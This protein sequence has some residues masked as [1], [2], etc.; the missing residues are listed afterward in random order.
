MAESSLKDRVVVLVATVGVAFALLSGLSKHLDWVAQLCGIF[1]QGCQDT[2]KF[3]IL[4][5]PVW[6]W[7]IGFFACLIGTALFLPRLVFWLSICGM[8]MELAFV[9]VMVSEK[10]LCVFCLVNLLVMLIIFGLCLDRRRVWQTLAM[11]ATFLLVGLVLVRKEEPP[12]AKVVAAPP[13]VVVPK[14]EESFAAQIGDR[15]ITWSELDTP[16]LMRI[17]DFN[18]QIYR[19][20]RERLE[21]MI[22][23]IVL[24]KE[25]ARQGKPLQQFVDDT[26]RADATEVTSEEIGRYLNENPA[27]KNNWKGT[28]EDLEKWVRATLQ[29]RKSYQMI[30][31]KARSLY[32]Q[33]GVV[34][35]LK[36]P[37][38]PRVQVNIEDAMIRGPEDAAVTLVEFSDYQCPACR[39]NH[40]TMKA[41]IESYKNEVK[42]VF[43]D[44]PLRMHQWAEKAAEASHC[45]AE[46]GKFAEY[47]DLLFGSN[48]EL[49]PEQLQAFAV[50]LGLVG[51]EFKSCLDGGKYR[52]T[53]DKNIQDGQSIGVNS[54]PTLVI[55]G[56]MIS[57]GQTVESLKKLIDEELAKKQ[58][59]KP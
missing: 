26:V 44:F 35:N 17:Y 55:N 40:E 2:S 24:S 53:V 51:E 39:K 56:R 28:P 6:I 37:E 25:A 20:K 30:M 11:V 29:Q 13:A 8:G 1:G 47:Q 21:Q 43:K 3:V 22:A 42:W 18:M 38:V 36:E 7:G 58:T 33:E 15:K 16:I 14:V 32:A 10:V 31:E 27:V 48:Q 52:E 23:Q 5:I 57:G 54:T 50:D 41:V 49:N 46:Q 19:L 34:I 12:V 9:W 4:S 45:A 59:L